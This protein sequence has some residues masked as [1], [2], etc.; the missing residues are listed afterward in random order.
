M[1]R[2]SVVSLALSLLVVGACTKRSKSDAEPVKG[3][4]DEKP[5][6][7]PSASS[8]A[9]NG[10]PE[11]DPVV[12]LLDAGKEPRAPMRMQAKQGTE[13]LVD[14]A[15]V[16]GIRMTLAG[17]AL[18]STTLPRI[19]TPMD[20]KVVELRPDGTRKISFS[21]DHVRVDGGPTVSPAIV[22]S[23]TTKLS[24]LDG[25]SGWVVVTDRGFN[26]ALSMNVPTDAPPLVKQMADSMKQ[27]MGQLV[28]PFP[29]EPVGVGA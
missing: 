8:V 21:V 18:P 12:E 19:H 5:K 11:A 24:A 22:S 16:M 9:T 14:L 4:S 20:V 26:R 1:H 13:Q 10:A 15:M 28:S 23:L 17:S 27:S 29:A 3:V 25:L 2:I 7:N 6:P